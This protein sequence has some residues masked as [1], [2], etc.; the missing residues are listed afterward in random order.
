M[1]KIAIWDDMNQCTEAEVKRMMPLVNE[2]RRQQASKYKHLFGQYCC[3]QSWLMLS[4]LLGHPPSEWRYN[5]HGKP[6]LIGDDSIT[7]FSISHCREAIAV[8]VADQEVGIDIESIRTAKSDLVTRV[9]NEAEQAQIRQSID[10]N[11]TFTR[12][13]TQK[14]AIVKWQGTGIEGMEMILDVRCRMLDVGCGMS[15][16]G[17]CMSDVGCET[18]EKEKYIYTII[19][20][21]LHCISA[22]I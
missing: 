17:C 19:Y 9:M 20:G 10:P 13:W 11:R 16:V 12:L 7:Y 21:K 22:E 5:E 15:D 18:I 2:Q 3:L 1:I 8:V 6:F 4:N 14:E